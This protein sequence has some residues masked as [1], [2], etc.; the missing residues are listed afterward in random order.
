[1]L[2]IQLNDIGKKFYHRWIFRGI[3]HDFSARPRLALVG[4]NGSGKSTLLRIIA[5]QL[6]PSAGQV[7]YTV[8]KRRVPVEQVYRYLSW[9]GPFTELYQDLTFREAL[10]LHFRFKTC[11][12]DQPESLIDILNLKDHADKNL[13]YYSSGMRQ[14]VKVGLALFTRSDILM[15]DEPT[16]NMDPE[17]A[18]MILNL[19]EEYRQGRVYILASNMQREY[20]SFED[21]LRL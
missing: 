1:M 20:Q 5:G 15:L 10:H 19:I 12:I 18:T 17:N 6:M 11:L 14:R 21:I 3:H 13:R 9:A 16:S 2:H 8:G 4:R 7:I